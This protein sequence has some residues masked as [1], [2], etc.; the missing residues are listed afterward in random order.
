[1]MK[2]AKN[3][4]KL[5]E[6]L[7]AMG[8]GLPSEAVRGLSSTVLNEE[9]SKAMEPVK[10]SATMKYLDQIHQKLQQ[11]RKDVDIGPFADKVDALD[12]DLQET[13]NQIGMAFEKITTEYDSKLGELNDALSKASKSITTAQA[14]DISGIL[15]ELEDIRGSLAFQSEDAGKNGLSLNEIMKSFDQRLVELASA[16]EGGKDVNG[17]A[18]KSLSLRLAEIESSTAE[19]GKRVDQ[20]RKEIMQRIGNLSGGGANRNIGIASNSSVL[21]TF[22]DINFQ[23]S[24]SLSWS[25]QVDQTNN[26][27]NIVASI[28]VSGASSGSPGGANKNV[29]FN[30]GGAFGGDPALNWSASIFAIGQQGSVAGKLSLDGRSS[31][32]LY[33][34]AP[35][36]ISDPWT[37]TLPTTDGTAGQYLLTDGNGVTQWASVTATGGSGITRAS[38]IITANTTGGN[39]ASTDYV[40]FAEAGMTFT[41]PTAVSNTNLYTVKNMAATS[42]LVATSAGQTIDGSDTALIA[43]QYEALSF[44]SNNSVWGVV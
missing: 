1:M 21:S 41:L 20:L 43:Q 39:T 25:A 10:N 29:Q 7:R 22:T 28:L 33:M 32:T 15:A 19:G 11:L 36:V 44:M 12:K 5:A 17:K 37:L 3:L 42:V 4:K 24:S 34:Q 31:G 38:S 16:I 14:R 30:N 6:K 40:Y 13:R 26:R 18:T 23:N 9:M 2:M 27:V 35:S 8:D